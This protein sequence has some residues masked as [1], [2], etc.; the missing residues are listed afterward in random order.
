MVFAIEKA[1]RRYGSLLILQRGE[2][3]IA[4]R[5]FLQHSNSKSWQN[6]E[7]SFSPL[8]EIPTG[9][10]V[11]LAPTKPVM[12]EGDVLAQGAL[13]TV[14]CRLETVMVGDQAAYQWGLCVKKGGEDTWAMQS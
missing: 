12:A 1:I 4:F 5:G 2:E 14:I 10:Y 6:M 8:G 13:K 9:Q 7:R 3:Q 11:L